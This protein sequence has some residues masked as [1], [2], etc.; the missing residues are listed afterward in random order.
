[1]TVATTLMVVNDCSSMGESDSEWSVVLD[2]ESG[3]DLVESDEEDERDGESSS[4]D[5]FWEA[6][7]FPC[8]DRALGDAGDADRQRDEAEAMEAMY[9]SDF[10]VVGAREWLFRYDIATGVSGE[11]RMRLP[12]DYPSRSPPALAM[13]V[14]NCHDIKQVQKELLRSFVPDTEVGFEWAER[15]RELCQVSAAEQQQCLRERHAEQSA[16][17]RRAADAREVAKSLVS[18]RSRWSTWT[19]QHRSPWALPSQEALS[20]LSLLEVAAKN[21]RRRKE[22]EAKEKLEKTAEASWKMSVANKHGKNPLRPRC[23]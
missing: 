12:A 3:A 10:A 21:K 7:Q 20:K 13:D 9:G 6:A 23:S 5:G 1:M 18:S 22:L 11:L 4:D 17:H 8:E 16:E 15:F 19:F 2:G 14:V